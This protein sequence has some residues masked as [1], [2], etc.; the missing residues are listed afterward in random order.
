MLRKCSECFGPKILRNHSLSNFTAFLKRKIPSML[1]KCSELGFSRSTPN[2]EHAQKML[3]IFW[4]RNA[5]KSCLQ[6]CYSISEKEK[7]RAC[8]ENAQNLVLRDPP[9][10]PRVLRKCSVLFGPKNAQKSCFQLFYSIFEKEKFRACSENA[11]NLVFQDPPPQ[12][13]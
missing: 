10:I 11:Q 12:K 13:F 6:L 3:R 8:S 9:K 7:F 4:P 1:R 2:S 5:Q